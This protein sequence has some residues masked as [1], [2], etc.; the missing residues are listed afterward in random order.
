MSDRGK[1]DIAGERAASSR[2]R[3]EGNSTPSLEP[4]E[5]GRETKRRIFQKRGKRAALSTTHGETGGAGLEI[6]GGGK[7]KGGGY[8]LFAIKRKRRGEGMVTRREKGSSPKGRITCA[9][10]IDA[11]GGGEPAST[12]Q[13]KGSSNICNPSGKGEGNSWSARKGE[14]GTDIVQGKG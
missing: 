10:L 9:L 13:E 2:T 1:K 7:R 12:Y 11:E 4:N 5:R 6:A 14:T 3:K 8:L